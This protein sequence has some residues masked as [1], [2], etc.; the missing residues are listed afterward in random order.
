MGKKK[1]GEKKLAKASSFGSTSAFTLSP[2][3]NHHLRRLLLL[4]ALGATQLLSVLGFVL[5]WLGHALEDLAGVCVCER[6]NE[7]S[8]SRERETEQRETEQRDVGERERGTQRNGDDDNKTPHPPPKKTSFLV[9]L[10]SLRARFRDEQG[11]NC[12]SF[13]EESR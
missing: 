9:F 3:M 7:R 8:S 12:S 4:L 11:W 10:H 2:T 6:E 5:R 13:C 1:K